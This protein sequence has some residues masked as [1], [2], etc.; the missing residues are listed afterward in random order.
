MS[1][2]TLT[3]FLLFRHLPDALATGIGNPFR[4]TNRSRLSF[5]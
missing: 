2:L 3:T 5:K 1:S 4:T